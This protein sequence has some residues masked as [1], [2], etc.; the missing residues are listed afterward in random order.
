MKKIVGIISII[1]CLMVYLIVGINNLFV[2]RYGILLITILSGASFISYVFKRKTEETI[3]ISLLGIIAILYIF[4]LLNL[5]KY[6]RYVV[7]LIY[8]LLGIYVLAKKIKDKELKEYIN[9][10]FTVGTNIFI[11]LY[12]VF[13]I[14]TFNKMFTIW[15]EYTYWSI[16]SKNMYY[17]NSFL[18]SNS[19]TV[20]IGLYPPNPTVLQYFFCKVIGMYSQGIEL[21][22]LNILGFAFLIDI[23]HNFKVKNFIT[24]ITTLFAIICIPNIF[25][26]QYFYITIY[27]DAILGIIIGYMLYKMYFSKC[28]T[29]KMFSMIIIAINISL[30]K[31][32]GIIVLLILCL[33]MLI[34]YIV[35]SI[36]E[37]KIKIKN[38]IRNSVYKK[39]I[40]L[41]IIMLLV[42]ILTYSSWNVYTS[43]NS[44]LRD[45]IYKI[46]D[47]ENL[48][49]SYDGDPI[50]YLFKAIYYTCFKGY[51]KTDNMNEDI[52]SLGS[53]SYDFLDKDYYSSKPFNMSVSTWIVITIISSIVIYNLLCDE[54]E[55]KKFLISTICVH[56]SELLYII[57]LQVAY[58][59]VFAN[60]EGIVHNSLQ[61]YLGTYLLAVVIYLVFAFI[62]YI[63][64]DKIK[65]TNSKFV[66]VACLIFVF[67]PMS[68][69]FNATITSGAY[70]ISKKELLSNE[71]NRA[72]YVISKVREEEKIYVINQTVSKDSY[73]LRFRYFVTPIKTSNVYSFSDTDE[74]DNKY[75]KLKEELFYKYDY[76]YMVQTDEYFNNFYK[77]IFKNDTITEWTLYKINKANGI[78]NV[79]LI[80][81]VE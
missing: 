4:G 17:S 54:N 20:A 3:I 50:T 15:D 14:T 8:N 58:M 38:I 5:L 49:K 16:A 34:Y 26:D 48:S 78:E 28:D 74:F 79:E 73:G 40:Y 59:L 12:I 39:E 64:N 72:N 61:R 43:H 23:F 32:T 44:E 62:N 30:I 7:L 55:K 33:C 29:F 6:G 47:E 53:F 67:T 80:P 63:N 52:K 56:F 21:F 13:A 77:K 57:F 68:Q 45:E 27:A 31:S 19:S 81:V 2:L 1:L 69:I 41:L 51:G 24:I 22:T 66:I 9:N 46:E 71:I 76:V 65:F 37:Q 18:M 75:L 35:V 42:G 36:Y 25:C 60:R 70:N 11:I 10:F